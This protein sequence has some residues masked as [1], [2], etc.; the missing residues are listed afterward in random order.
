MG[1]ECLFEIGGLDS[2]EFAQVGEGKS[3]P[4]KQQAIGNHRDDF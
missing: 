2:F 3:R 1:T 4:Q